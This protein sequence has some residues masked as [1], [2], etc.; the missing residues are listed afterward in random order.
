MARSIEE[1][2]ADIAAVQQQMSMRNALGYKTARAKAILDHDTSGLE[3]IYSLMNQAEQNKLQREAQQAFQTSERE[4]TQKFQAEQNDLNRGLQA[5]QYASSKEEA[6]AKAMQMLQD[7][8]TQR[9]NLPVMS[10][11]KDI[12]MAD[13]ALKFAIAHAKN[14]GLTGLDDYS[15]EGAGSDYNK[16]KEDFGLYSTFL[17]NEDMGA[18]EAKDKWLADF[19]RNHAD[20][21]A[22]KTAVEVRRSLASR[23]SK[24]QSDKDASTVKLLDDALKNKEWDRVEKYIGELYSDVLKNEYG[25]KYTAAKNRKGKAEGKSNRR[26][27]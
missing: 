4:A 21:P 20:D 16:L 23:K 18:V 2:D 19:I 22:A 26:F 12:A 27:K 13:A 3:R 10:T 5:L 8:F 7:A 24:L 9:K 14:Q 17:G 15:I 1:I 11:D 6:K 25:E